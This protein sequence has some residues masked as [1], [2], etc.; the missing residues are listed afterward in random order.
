MR[1]FTFWLDGEDAKNYGIILQDAI[2]FSEAEPIYDAETIPGRNGDLI[3]E[4]GSFENRSGNADCYLLQKNAYNAVG[5]ANRFLLGKRGYRRLQTSDDPGH[6]WMAIVENGVSIENIKNVLFPFEIGF[7]CKPQRFLIDGEKTLEFERDS[8]IVN[9][10]GFASLPKITI[11]GTGAGKLFISGK[12]IVIKE[13]PTGV[14]VLDSETQN[15]YDNT[16]NMNRAIYAPEFPT[17]ISGENEI[18]YVGD[19]DKIDIMPRWWEL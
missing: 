6:Y 19:I 5:A 15:A 2:S 9:Q 1:D 14:L 13:N 10:Y 4:T 8:V 17:L 12:E 7:D 11:Y 16:G 3:F 18:S